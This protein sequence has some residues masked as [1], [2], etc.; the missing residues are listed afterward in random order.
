VALVGGLLLIAGVTAAIAVL[1]ASGGS[2]APTWVT[3]EFEQQQSIR[4]LH[5]PSNNCSQPSLA[6]DGARMAFIGDRDGSVYVAQ[7]KGAFSSG[8]TSVADADRGIRPSLDKTGRVVFRD[9]T[10]IWYTD[11]AQQNAK[12]LTAG[13]GDSDPVWS[14]GG[15]QVAF[16]STTDNKSYSL[17]KIDVLSPGKTVE[18]DRVARGAK[19]SVPAW[20]PDGTRLAYIRSS[21]RC[22]EQGEIWILKADGSGAPH[23]LL[24][25]SGDERRPTWSPDSKQ[26][27]FSSNVADPRNYDLYTVDADGNH[28]ARRTTGPKDEVGPS[29]GASGIAYA[30]GDFECGGG[31]DQQ[32]WFAQLVD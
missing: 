22:P 1:L 23:R 3:D 10:G 5:C 19:I 12:Q 2:E 17:L 25:L 11:Q 15:T 24:P 16:T 30:R 8:S 14:P 27:A 18:L 26:I 21:A 6:P 20:S 9:P 7:M 4:N 28:L 31:S 29:W 32:L 13:R